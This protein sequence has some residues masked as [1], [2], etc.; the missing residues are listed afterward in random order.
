MSMS[1]NVTLMLDNLTFAV[2]RIEADAVRQVLPGV[3]LSDL[4][5]P[6][7]DQPQHLNVLPWFSALATGGDTL[8]DALDRFAQ[9]LTPNLSDEAM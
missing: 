4:D 6:A 7:S 2:K 8:S 1:A 3:G 9:H 5:R